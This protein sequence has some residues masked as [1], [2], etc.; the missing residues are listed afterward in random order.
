MNSD[1]SVH[2]KEDFCVLTSGIH[3]SLIGVGLVISSVIF[4]QL[5]NALSNIFDARVICED[6]E[7]MFGHGM[8]ILTPMMT[9]EV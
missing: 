1:I 3:A 5:I 6:L 4:V 9:E 8:E 2:L 7:V